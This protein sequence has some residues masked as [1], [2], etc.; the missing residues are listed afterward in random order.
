MRSAMLWSKTTPRTV[1]ATRPLL[2]VGGRRSESPARK[3]WERG[4]HDSSRLENYIVPNEG[5]L[6]QECTR[7]TGLTQSTS[8]SYLKTTILWKPSIVHVRVDRR[9]GTLPV[10]ARISTCNA[11]ATKL[12][13]C[14]VGSSTA[15]DRAVA[16]IP[17]LKHSP[18]ELTRQPSRVTSDAPSLN[19]ERFR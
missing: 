10:V 8:L 9:Q 3:Q 15:P 17:S 14:C 18:V 2:R 1:S 5:Y 13:T 4:L 16:V 19:S 6:Q 11:T 12:D 7:D